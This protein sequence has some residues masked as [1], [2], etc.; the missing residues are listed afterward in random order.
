MQPRKAS[1]TASEKIRFLQ[2]IREHLLL[3]PDEYR[4]LVLYVLRRHRQEYRGDVN[5]TAADQVLAEAA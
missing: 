5:D 1:L 2:E 4:M 3:S